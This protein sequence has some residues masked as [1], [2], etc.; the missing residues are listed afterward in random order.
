MERAVAQK[1]W[2]LVEP[3][4]THQG[5]EVVEIEVHG[6][7]N[8]VV[9]IFLDGPDGIS[10]GKCAEFSRQISDMLDVEDPIKSHYT[11]EVSSP[12]FDRPLRKPAHFLK[13][14]GHTVAF[15]LEAPGGKIEKIRGKLVAAAEE[16]VTIEEQKDRT[17]VVKLSD[18]HSAN[19]IYAWDKQPARKE[20]V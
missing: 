16:T 6:N 1:L 9:R 17:R 11:L 18:V 3:L 8:A 10:I 20:S 14:V 19:L 7:R 15:K 13:Q 5:F 12:G 2:P 4:V